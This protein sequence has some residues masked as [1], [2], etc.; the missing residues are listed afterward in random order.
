MLAPWCR[1]GRVAPLSL[2]YMPIYI[3]IRG[4]GAFGYVGR[5]GTSLFTTL[6]LLWAC[7]DPP[8]DC[9]LLHFGHLGH[10]GTLNLTAIYYTLATWGA[11][12]LPKWPEEVPK[13]SKLVPFHVL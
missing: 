13:G 11:K 8:L 1:M 5:F 4:P 2:Y 7:G 10:F 3:W 12:E 9:Y 6:W